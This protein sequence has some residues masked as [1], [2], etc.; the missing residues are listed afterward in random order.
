[1]GAKTSI[2]IVG[3]AGY[4]G[5]HCSKAVAEA[6]FLPIAYDNLVTGHTNFVRWGP[7]IVGDVQDSAKIA[8]V[9]REHDAKAVMHFAAFSAVGESVADP[10]KYYLNNVAGTLG[11]LRGMREAGCS[12]LVFSSTGAVY[13]NAGREPIVESA[14]GP[15]VNPY[16]RSK[17]MIEQILADYRSAYRLNSVCLRYFN[18]CGADESATIGELRDA[19]THLIPRALMALQGYVSDFAIF[20]TDY[21]TPDGTAIRDYIHVDDL[22]AAHVAALNLLFG[23]D[24]GGVFN[25]GTGVGYS[26]MQIL[27]AIHAETG[28]EVPLR[29]RERRAG[30]PP[31][32][33]GRSAHSHS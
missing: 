10:E 3:G 15:A 4:I 29:V 27:D 17:F 11:L 20:G 1:M 13:G 30:D 18:A 31:A 2:L 22:A 9:I 5:S 32:P 28:V 8:S 25:V 23:G 7:L 16:G 12:L 19:E 6:G 14:A 33:R 21:D 26:V 24:S